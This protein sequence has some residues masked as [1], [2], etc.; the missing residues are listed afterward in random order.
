MAFFIRT[1]ISP[2]TFFWSLP[3][4]VERM[5]VGIDRMM[6][7]PVLR[8][9]EGHPSLQ[10]CREG[11]WMDNVELNIYHAFDKENSSC[12]GKRFKE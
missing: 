1:I 7:H 8:W 2:P 6:T 12:C 11:S 3:R 9:C 5:G 10:V 4:G